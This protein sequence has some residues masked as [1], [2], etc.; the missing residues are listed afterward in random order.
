[1]SSNQIN[2]D[3]SSNEFT[4]DGSDTSLPEHEPTH[5]EPDGG[6]G[7]RS[8]LKGTIAGMASAAA[9]VSFGSRVVRAADMVTDYSSLD[10]PYATGRDYSKIPQRLHKYPSSERPRKSCTNP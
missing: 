1:M 6:I 4:K 9:A 10:N 2:Q 8:F 7:C 5:S 3:L